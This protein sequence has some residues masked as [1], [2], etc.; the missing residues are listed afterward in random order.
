MPSLIET[1]NMGKC[2][3]FMDFA[4]AKHAVFLSNTEYIFLIKGL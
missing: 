2:I 1:V 4:N 3:L